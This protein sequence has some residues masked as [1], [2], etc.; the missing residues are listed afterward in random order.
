MFLHRLGRQYGI[1]DI[2]LLDDSITDEQLTEHQ[3]AFWIDG[4][5]HGQTHAAETVAEIRN[6]GNRLVA[7]Q[8]SKPKETAESMTWYSGQ[9]I[10]KRWTATDEKESV[11]KTMLQP[12]QV[13]QEIE[14]RYG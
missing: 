11:S 3:A 7:A 4:L 5:Y 12:D 10:I 6:L 8:S 2:D 1:I 13:F 9:D 14:R